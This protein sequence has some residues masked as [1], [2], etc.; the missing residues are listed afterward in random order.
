MSKQSPKHRRITIQQRH[1]RRRKMRK[2]KA[3]YNQTNNQQRQ[4]EL[5][6][7]LHRMSPQARLEELGE[8]EVRG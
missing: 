8:E 5:E 2:I 3:E 1:K 7:K 6:R 4:A